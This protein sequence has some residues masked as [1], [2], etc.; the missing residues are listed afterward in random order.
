MNYKVISWSAFVA[1]LVAVVL[2]L[3][4]VVGINQSLQAGASG[5]RW[6]NGVSADT[7]SPIA[8]QLRGAT[9]LLTSS[10]SL[11]STGTTTLSLLSSSATKGACIP[12][13]ATSTNTLLNLTFGATTSA[14]TVGVEPI[15]RYGACS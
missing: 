8:G 14:T 1:S 13:N 2:S 3:V 4:A 7:T 11:T 5:T 9:L 10:A 12:F 15:I 6:P